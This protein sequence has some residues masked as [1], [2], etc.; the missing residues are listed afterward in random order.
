M[1]NRAKPNLICENYTTADSSLLAIARLIAA[2]MYMIVVVCQAAD[3]EPYSVNLDKTGNAQL[4]KLLQDAST[5][6]SLRQTAEVGPF[7][8]I[9]R[10]KQDQERFTA[11]LHS[12]GYYKGKVLL[13]IAGR[14]PD[15]PELLDWVTNAPAD[16]PTPVTVGFELGPRFNLGQIKLQGDVPQQALD[17]LKLK[18][19]DAAVAADVSAARERLLNALREQGHA[20]AKVD[21][22]IATLHE[23]ADNVD[24]LFQV[25]SGPKLVLGKIA[26][27][28]LK[29]INA[30]F[31]SNRLL[32]AS[33][34]QYKSTAVET[35]RQDL[36]G[37]GVFSSVRARVETQLD[38]QGRVPISFD[39]IERQRH[40][41][42]VGGAYSTDLG[43]SFSSSWLHRNLFGNAEQLNLT[44]ALT[45][46]GGNSTTGAGFKL[47]A[48][49]NKPDFLQRDQALQ[50]EVDAIKQS[51]IAYNQDA[52][53]ADLMLN[54]KLNSHWNGGFGIAAQQSRISQEGV[55]RDYTL[56]SLPLSLKYNSSNSPLD[57]TKG[58]MASVA[59]TPTQSLAGADKKPFV[60]MQV[61]AST[62]LDLGTPG[63]SVLAL[64]GMVGDSVGASQ[65]DLPPDKRFYAGGSA[66][67]RGYKFQSIGPEFADNNPQGGTAM[68]AG[69]V[70]F[71]QRIFE[72][73]GFALFTDAG[74]VSANA[75]P[76]A[77]RWQIGAG[78]GA[79]YYTA[80]GPIRLD[81]ALPV[82]P[83]PGSGSF[84]AYIG[85]GQ[86]F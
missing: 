36:A 72:D 44:A 22:P 47:A 81:V 28:G 79:R 32:I 37:L 67:V 73:Y 7:A 6:I 43:G 3:P 49:F 86:A 65:F 84:E 58:A 31:V 42:N 80:F 40:A 60:V 83:Q 52:V 29:K 16:S 54:R 48:A 30:D 78:V 18:T 62:Y 33:G 21:E 35:A 46:L 4:D 61:S 63:R 76:F 56:L 19:G 66:T 25:D 53:M 15:D 20:L 14:A 1:T 57:P 77:S 64:R 17:A 59:V 26:V 9:T 41:V 34:Q 75:A 51:L 68:V 2:A 8:L 27:N 13:R 10:A 12:L 82:N 11:A 39:V 5:L 24:I 45:Q 69:G 23:D 50:F 85:L 55:T 38:Q 70:E 71:R 74:Q